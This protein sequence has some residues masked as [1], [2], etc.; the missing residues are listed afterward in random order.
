[1]KVTVNGKVFEDTVCKMQLQMMFQEFPGISEKDAKQKVADEIIR[2]VLLQEA[3]RREIKQVSQSDIDKQ[4]QHIKASYPSEAE[5]EKMLTM[6][7]INEEIIKHNIADD[8]R[9]NAFI[10]RLTK[11]IPPAPRKVIEEFYKREYRASLK[12]KQ[13]HAAH[14]VKSFTPN[15]A[16]RVYKEMLA[17]RK[18]LLEGA[19]FQTIADKYSSCNDEGGDLGW[20]TRGKMVEEFDVILFSM[21]PGEISPIFQTHFG[22]HIATVFDVKKEEKMSLSECMDDLKQ[23]IHN[24]MVGEF[25]N[26]WLEK[27]K[28]NAKIEI[29]L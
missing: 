7:G 22:Y 11:N 17:I 20:F 27:V 16:E 15:T 8:F 1:M 2:H 26:N 5:F 4:F 21:N 28:P 3:A 25:L 29:E 10:K 18:Q 9:I 19:D 14:I 12:P 13:I 23:L 6:N 24:R